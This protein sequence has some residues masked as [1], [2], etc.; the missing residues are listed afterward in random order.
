M[1]QINNIYQN[2][3]L[4]ENY[5]FCGTLRNEKIFN[6]HQK[7]FLGIGQKIVEGEIVGIHQSQT[8]NPEYFYDLKLP[9]KIFNNQEIVEN[10]SCTYIFESKEQ[11]KQSAIK[12]LENCYN[13]QKQQIENYFK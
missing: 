9:I 2:Q 12:N 4:K 10:M 13:L 6:L 1:Y 11:A 7:I 3:Y 8:Q 5:E